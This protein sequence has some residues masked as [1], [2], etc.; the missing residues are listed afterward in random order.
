VLDGPAKADFDLGRLPLRV[1]LRSLQGQ[2]LSFG[3]LLVPLI[4]LAHSLFDELSEMLHLA[5]DLISRQYRRIGYGQ[6][7][8]ECHGFTLI[9][10]E[11]A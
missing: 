5:Q 9:V 4:S 8:L 1:G 2:L 6:I 7:P 3:A 10:T 11:S